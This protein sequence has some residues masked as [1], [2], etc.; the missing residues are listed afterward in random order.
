MNKIAIVKKTVSTIVGIG[1]TK[2][3]SGIIENNVDTDTTTSK[4][5]VAAASTAIGFAASDAIGKY[6]D[7]QID[8]IA[9]WWKN[10]NSENATSE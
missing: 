9:S 5:T 7:N 2:I 4:V 10:R 3:V 6:T 1:V 8:E